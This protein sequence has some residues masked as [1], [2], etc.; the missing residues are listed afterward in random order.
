MWLCDVPQE[1]ARLMAHPRVYA[2]LHMPVQAASN[3]VLGAMRREY[4]VEDFC[5]VVDEL[6]AKVSQC[7]QCT[8]FTCDRC[9]V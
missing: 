1:I 3:A 7:M 4:V 8:S 6:R 5:R 9:L 2:F